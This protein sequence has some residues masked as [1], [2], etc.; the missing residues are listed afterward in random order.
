MI[1]SKPFQSPR[2]PFTSK[3][4][5]HSLGMSQIIAYGLLFYLFALVKAPLAE[6][7]G[8]SEIHILSVLSVIVGI[9]AFL[10]PVFGYWADK[11][12]A[13]IVMVFGLFSGGVGLAFLSFGGELIWLYIGFIF[14]ALG[15][16]GATYELAF[17]AAVQLDEGKSRKN[18]S[19]ITFYGSV[20]SS[21]TWLLVGPMLETFGLSIML[22]LLCFIVW[23]MAFRLAWLAKKNTSHTPK[24]K[25]VISH[26]RWSELQKSEKIAMV[27]LG[28]SGGGWLSWL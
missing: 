24:L 26:F 14:I 18:I 13:L 20:A 7:Y 1:H 23:V 19:Y 2:G 5:I 16:G 15:I 28:L 9:Q 25:N 4:P 8:I 22:M 17:T 12:S 10:G 21:L 27:L 3:V 6:A 11:L